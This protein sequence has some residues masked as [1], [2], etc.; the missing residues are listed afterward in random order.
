MVQRR[1]TVSGLVAAVC[2]VI[3]AGFVEPARAQS[4]GNRP[5]VFEHMRQTFAEYAVVAGDDAEARLALHDQAL[6]HWTVQ[7]SGRNDGALFLWLQGER[8]AVVGCVVTRPAK[9][10]IYH[11][12]HS[13][14]RSPITATLDGRTIWHPQEPG[15]RLEPLPEAPEPAASSA[16]R[17]TQIRT[18]AR[19]FAVSVVHQ[20]DGTRWPTRML[21]RPLYEYSGSD[22]DL[23]DGGLFLF[24]RANDPQLLVVLE[25]R[26]GESGDHWQYGAARLSSNETSIEHNGQVVQTIARWPWRFKPTETRPRD[27]AYAQFMMGTYPAAVEAE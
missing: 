16:R 3:A 7:I 5:P 18:L 2:W 26:R 4:P 22:G 19:K 6:Y 27:E 8:P 11:E 10:V 13:L 24:V 12:F 23:L 25:A 14:S 1:Q 9:R 15:L 21:A 17:R 20:K